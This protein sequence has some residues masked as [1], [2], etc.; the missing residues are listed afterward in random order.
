M[1][2]GYFDYKLR[3]SKIEFETLMLTGASEQIKFSSQ[4]QNLADR[5]GPIIALILI[6]SHQT[7]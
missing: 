6:N 2:R 4:E 1:L 5:L 3:Q 7:R